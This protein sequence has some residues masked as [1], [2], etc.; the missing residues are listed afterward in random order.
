M[1][2]FLVKQYGNAR[3]ILPY[4][5][6]ETLSKYVLNFL[7]HFGLKSH[8]WK[9]YL[10]GSYYS[11]LGKYSFEI[12]SHLDLFDKILPNHVNQT[13]T[14][15]FGYLPEKIA[16]SY[17]RDFNRKKLY[18]YV[19]SEEK[20]VFLKIGFGIKES[21]EI[22]HEAEFYSKIKNFKFAQFKVV[23]LL[24]LIE[25]KENGVIISL[26]EP[27]PLGCKTVNNINSKT[28]KI[29]HEF[30]S[31]E[32][33]TISLGNIHWLKK[34]PVEEILIKNYDAN[35]RVELVT[36]HGDFTPWNILNHDNSFYLI[37]FEETSTKSPLYA[38]LLHFYLAKAA[39]L[40]HSNLTTL[41]YSLLRM[42]KKYH[43]EYNSFELLFAL[44]HE[45][46]KSNSQIR[47]TIE[48][49]VASNKIPK[50]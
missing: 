48:E 22:K 8:I 50:C 23:P 1:K 39:Y 41:I 13:L 43:I 30:K 17:S 14:S 36:S 5:K 46:N 27:L 7:P 16:I 37:D 15:L 12:I 2:Y 49:M 28:L 42:L 24:D 21:N 44:A 38:D 11:G 40:K 20:I 35:R 32:K 47:N 10:R 6:S 25:D 45:W 34:N 3:I 31:I 19:S 29:L 4:D 18:A 33:S 26:F 9:W